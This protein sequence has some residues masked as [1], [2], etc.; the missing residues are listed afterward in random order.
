MCSAICNQISE[1]VKV[2]LEQLGQA[3]GVGVQTGPRTA[4]T[5]QQAVHSQHLLLCYKIR[6]YVEFPK[7]QKSHAAVLLN[8]YSP[9]K[10]LGTGC[11]GS[12]VVFTR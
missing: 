6:L 4:E 12:N 10:E 2:K 5:L 11:S 3:G 9:E 7:T 1:P 8:A